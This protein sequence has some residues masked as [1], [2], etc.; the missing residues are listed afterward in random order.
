MIEQLIEALA[1]A[2]GDEAV[3]SVL[4]R[5]DGPAF[6]VGGDVKLFHA[7]LSGKETLEDQSPDRLHVAIRAIA[8]LPK[9]VVAAVHG[10]CAGAAL[11]M[12]SACDLA[13]A[14]DTAQFS[15]AFLGI[16]ASPDGGTTYFLPRLLGRRRAMEVLLNPM[17]FSAER[18]EAIGLI[19]Q[20]TVPADLLDTARGVADMV[21]QGPVRANERLKRLMSHTHETQLADQLRDESTSMQ[22]SMADDEFKEGVRAFV[23]KRPPEFLGT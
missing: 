11:G 7:I 4:L 6:C 18:A 5:G 22:A 2:A 12:I 16:G 19:N 21:A 13:L 14:A 20:C 10:A 15:S 23:A 3:R 8:E 1:M 9:I 17:P